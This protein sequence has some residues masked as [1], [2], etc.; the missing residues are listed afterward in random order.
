VRDLRLEPRRREQL[1]E[2][3]TAVRQ[4]EQDQ[5]LPRQVAQED[6][7]PAGERVAGRQ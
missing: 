5:F 3:V 6:P 1:K 4:V 7:V 2:V